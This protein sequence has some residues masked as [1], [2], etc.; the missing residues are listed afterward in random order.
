MKTWSE[1]EI[2]RHQVAI[3]G[4]VVDGQNNPVGG[5]QVSI[6]S[7]P[8]AFSARV[9]TAASIPH[10]QRDDLKE[11][12]DRTLTKENGR[13]YFLDLPGGKYTLNVIDTQT[14]SQDEKETTVS[15]DKTGKV[16]RVV[17]NLKVARHF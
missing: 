3:C 12:P 11:H 8:K 2:I 14:D 5:I 16:N 15:W 6:V 7:M 13:F 10:H 9:S 1:W 4:R 17:L